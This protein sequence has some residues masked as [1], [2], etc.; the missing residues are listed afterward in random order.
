MQ[1]HEYALIGG[2]NRAKVGRWLSLVAAAV[3]AGCV[4]LLLTLV[5]LAKLVG[6][7]AT[8]PPSVLSLVGAGAVFSVL[9]WLFDRYIWRWN[10]LSSLL[11]VP[12]LSGDWECVGRTLNPDGTTKYEWQGKITILQSWDKL[13]VR[14]KTKS[15]GSN[16]ITAALV[17]DPIDGYV[18]LYHYKNEP[19]IGE[20][21]LRE[22]RGCAEL[23]FATDRQSAEGEYFNGYGRDTFGTLRL[24]RA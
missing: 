16:S 5:D 1:D 14:L 11:K 9:Y 21:A 6:V 18:L 2:M 3:S 20:A 19:I 10:P 22:H 24:K 15:S 17:V 23:K 8:L 4:F 13:R 12:D 7:N